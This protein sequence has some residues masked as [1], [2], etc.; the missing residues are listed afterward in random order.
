MTL[1]QHAQ[2]FIKLARTIETMRANYSIAAEVLRRAGPA[3]YPGATVYRVRRHKVRA[4]WRS[5]FVAVRFNPQ[6][7]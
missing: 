3:K 6:H 7:A 4:H 2:A 5:E 1:S